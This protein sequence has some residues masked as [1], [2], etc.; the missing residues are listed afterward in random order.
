MAKINLMIKQI[1]YFYTSE[2]TSTD[3]A[4]F[5]I[6]QPIALMSMKHDHQEP[7][8]RIM[9]LNVPQLLHLTVL[10]FIAYAVYAVSQSRRLLL[11]TCV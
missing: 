10:V 8:Y 4:F 9:R 1:Y 11:H 7:G 3:Q 5:K 2:M 6:R